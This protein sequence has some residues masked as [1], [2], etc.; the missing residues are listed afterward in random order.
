MSL[1]TGEKDGLVFTIRHGR[2]QFKLGEGNAHTDLPGERRAFPGDLEVVPV[3]LKINLT[4]DGDAFKPEWIFK[5]A[6]RSEVVMTARNLID[7][8]D[9]R[10]GDV[11]EVRFLVVIKDLVI[12]TTNP[13]D[14]DGSPSRGQTRAFVWKKDPAESAPPRDAKAALLEHIAAIRL[15]QTEDGEAALAK[16]ELQFTSVADMTTSKPDDS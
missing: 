6:G 13:K 16:D 9:L 1:G 5:A 11:V 8:Y 10:P 4:P 15:M 12:A 14:S 3:G 7:I 2:L